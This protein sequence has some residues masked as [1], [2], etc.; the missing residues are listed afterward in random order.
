MRIGAG[1]AVPVG[2]F[3]PR[4]QYADGM[5]LYQYVQSN[6]IG[7]IDP[8]GLVS[9]PTWNDCCSDFIKCLEAINQKLAGTG[10]IL[11]N[12]VVQLDK[13]HGMTELVYRAYSSANAANA[14]ASL[15][16]LLWAGGKGA[17]PISAVAVMALATKQVT[18]IVTNSRLAL[19]GAQGFKPLRAW[20]KAALKTLARV[21]V[22]AMIA[23]W[24]VSVGLDAVKIRQVA[25]TTTVLMNFERQVASV[26]DAAV[27]R[28]KATDNAFSLFKAEYEKFNGKAWEPSHQNACDQNVQKCQLLQ[29]QLQARTKQL[30]A[31]AAGVSNLAGQAETNLIGLIDVKH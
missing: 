18:G 16:S 13:L 1:G 26:R 19:A 6:P 8:M 31:W 3:I 22:Y 10:A 24:A 25:E 11:G 2:R 28:F 4:D 12:T 20:Q 15:W 14:D 30:R 7:R 23:D 17:K 21:G 29:K 27:L 5:N 9:S